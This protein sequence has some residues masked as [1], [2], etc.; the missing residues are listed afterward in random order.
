MQKEILKH[1]PKIELH[2][3]IEGTF[4]PETLFHISQ[5]NNLDFP[6]NFLEF[7]K[8]LQFPEN[9]PP[10][11]ALFLSKF[12]NKWY[13]SLDDVYTVVYNSFIHIDLNENL[14]YS[15]IRFNPFHFC[16][17]KGFDPVETLKIFLEAFYDAKKE[18]QYNIKLLMTINRGFYSEEQYIELFKQFMKYV[19]F[20]DIV[21][22]DLAGDEIK[23]PPE[24]FINFFNFIQS[25][26][27]PI[28]IHAG[29]IT[30]AQQI[31]T[32]IKYLHAKRIGHGV[33]IIEDQDL[34]N[35]VRE[36]DIA[37]EM[38]PISNYQTGAYTDFAT[39]PIK[40]LLNKNIRVTLNS[41]DPTVQ[42]TTLIDDYNICAEHM[43]FSLDDFKTLNLNAI[44]ASFLPHTEKIILKNNFLKAWSASLNKS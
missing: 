4:H 43:K 11:F 15:E 6:K 7:K 22:V 36:K 38:C 5:K 37:F 2:R 19:N 12:Y 13:Y 14:F 44:H 24:N 25:C 34:I 29:E 31:W 30:S 32:S 3:H 39:H 18:T 41:D 35:Y 26:K 10:D 17:H 42:N 40:Q 16:V 9:S 21:G 1:L 8:Q 23:F 20:N 27:L 33:K 28:T